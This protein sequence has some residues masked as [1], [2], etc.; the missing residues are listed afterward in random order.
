MVR[1]H[2]RRAYGPDMSVAAARAIA[3][4]L[5]AERARADLTQ[6][7]LAARLGWSQQKVG[8][9]ETGVR[10]LYADEFPD[11]A[12]ALGVPLVKLLDGV[13]PADLRAL[14]LIP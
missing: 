5:R 13:D 10:R 6:A 9:I 11:V 14:G 7:E 8:S 2:R 1:H 3:R 12:L 4:S